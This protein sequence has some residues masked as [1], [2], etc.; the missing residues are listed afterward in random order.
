MAKLEM[1]RYQWLMWI[2]IILCVY[3]YDKCKGGAVSSVC[4]RYH[5]NLF[6]LK[7]FWNALNLH[8]FIIRMIW[9]VEKKN[10]QS[11]ICHLYD[12]VNTTFIVIFIVYN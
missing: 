7:I 4:S 3:V 12:R 9:G 11:A 1:L 2:I 5:H 6:Q 10:A 8:R